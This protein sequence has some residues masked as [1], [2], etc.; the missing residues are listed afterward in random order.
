VPDNIDFHKHT[1]FIMNNYQEGVR[2]ENV[3]IIS[4]NVLRPEVFEKLRTIYD[5]INNITIVGQQNENLNLSNLCF[6]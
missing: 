2:T 4:D 3:M 5:A 6:K 1:K